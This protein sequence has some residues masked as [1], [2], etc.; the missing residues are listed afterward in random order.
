[1]LAAAVEV[2]VQILRAI[3][4]LAVLQV[5]LVVA[6]GVLCIRKMLDQMLASQAQMA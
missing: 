1:L 2:F 5:V 4:R 6:A 3:Q